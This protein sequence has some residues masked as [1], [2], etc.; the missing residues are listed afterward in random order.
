MYLKKVCVNNIFLLG[1]KI[2]LQNITFS[3]K[4]GEFIIIM[5][6]SGSGKSTLLNIIGTID[7]PSQ[8]NVII[9]SIPINSN[10]FKKLYYRQKNM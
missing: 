6:H 5:G 4:E 9:D 1:G 2:A 8:G 3:I 7:S 10:V